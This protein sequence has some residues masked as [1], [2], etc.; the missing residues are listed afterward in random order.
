MTNPNATHITLIADRT[1]SMQSVQSDAEGAINALLEDQRK[2]PDKCSLLLVDFDDM[3][4]FRTV[5]DGEI[6]NSVD[7]KLTPR[8]NTPLYDAIGKGIVTT[9]ERLAALAEDDR[10]G[11]VIFVVQ[12]DGQ[13][14]ASREFTLD[15]VN[16][17]IDEQ[18]EKWQWTFVFLASGPAGWSASRAFANT[19]LGQ[20]TYRTTGTAKSH[21]AT[22]NYMSQTLGAVRGGH[23]AAAAAFAGGGDIDD[24]GTVTKDEDDATS[25]KR[26]TPLP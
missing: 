18:T 9:G 11:K 5:F 20:N 14:N 17:M 3:E 19:S 4:P 2:L 25:P 12:T 8:G 13:E 15:R 10:P 16:A 21:E 6:Q 1:G 22:A 26:M 24:D 23:V 7:Y